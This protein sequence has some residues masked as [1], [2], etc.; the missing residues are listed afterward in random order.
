MKL[1]ILGVLFITVSAVWSGL[2]LF[3]NTPVTIKVPK[4][5]LSLPSPPAKTSTTP[6]AVV[7]NLP[8]SYEIRLQKHVY[9]TFNNCG[10]A[11]LS[12]ALSYVNINQSQ[13]EIGQ[14]LRPYQVAGGNNDDKSVTFTELAQ[15][16]K[17]YNVTT[18]H[19]PNGSIDIL[20]KFIANDIAVLT[21]TWLKRGE[22][23]GHYRLVRGYDETTGEIIQDDS[24]QNKNLRF[25]Y[26]GFMELWQGF[27]Y[28]YLIIVPPEKI[29]IV[30]TILGAEVDEKI[31][32]K[33][34]LITAQAEEL[35]EPENPFFKFNQSIA[36]YHL[37]KFGQA[38]TLFEE[39]ENK[40]PMRMLWYQIEPI[41]S[42]QKL[43][44]YSRVLTMTENILNNHNRAFS[45]LYIIRGEIYLEQ[46]NK[47]AARAEFEKAVFYNK[48]LEKAQELLKSAS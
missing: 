41:L 32:W 42:Y 4:P 13:A 1:F 33:N 20:K 21:R 9:Q 46:G 31:A 5:L 43:K 34:A 14:A 8:N 45:E 10:P 30:E 12:M 47:E 29:T 3:R 24:L 16:A 25:S 38:A 6:P 18:F 28:E 35:T 11:S 17:K 22:D 19:R 7:N 39:V 27:N 40:L 2:P 15:Y 26:A 44:N 36:Q 23:V 37:G 48:N